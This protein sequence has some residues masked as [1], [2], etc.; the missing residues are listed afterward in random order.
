MDDVASVSLGS[1]HSSAVKTDG[2][3]WMWGQ[4]GDYQ[5]GDD[6]TEIKYTPQKLMDDVKFSV[7]GEENSA[8]V[9]TDGTLWTWG[10][11]SFGECGA[12]ADYPLANLSDCLY[13]PEYVTD[14]V[15]N[16][17]FGYYSGAAV[18]TDGSLWIWGDRLGNEYVQ[19]NP[20][21]EILEENVLGAA[22]GGMG[23]MLI[24][25]DNSLWAWGT[26]Y[27]GQLGSQ[28]S[29]S[30][31]VPVD[32]TGEFAVG[33][34]VQERSAGVEEQIPEVY[35][36]GTEETDSNLLPD[37]AVAAKVQENEDGTVTAEVTGLTA[38]ESYNLYSMKTLDEA[39]PFG[40][41]TL[42]YIIQLQADENGALR[43]TFTP[44]ESSE[45]S[46]TFAVKMADGSGSP[47]DI[48]DPE[49]TPGDVTED[50]EVKIDD[51]RTVLR[52][53]C[54]KITLTDQQKLAA[55]VEENGEVDIADL[56]KMLRFV[57]G[58]IESL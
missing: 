32:I 20:E 9:K 26:N 56:R 3:L 40:A 10:A 37:T 38:G 17:T 18:K 53:V 42:L 24:E 12:I 46:V 15:V 52:A 47:G 21:L 41:D 28:I 57:C 8:A 48:E 13:T 54:R 7:M 50:G 16:V 58:K 1:W 19:R 25:E 5:L 36:S 43:T 33:P 45:T 31:E 39:D 55:D 14:D 51:L 30:T 29:D 23:A 27:D 11:N 49:Y 4:N 6:T 34:A 44:R 35:V 2:S 22:M